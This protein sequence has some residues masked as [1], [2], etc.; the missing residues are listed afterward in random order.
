MIH[1]TGDKFTLWNLINAQNARYDLH[2]NRK[3]PETEAALLL[4]SRCRLKH[5]RAGEEARQ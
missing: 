4:M 5:E 3:D 1:I 2:R